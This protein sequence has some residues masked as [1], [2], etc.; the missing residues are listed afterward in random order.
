VGLVPS[1]TTLANG[2]KCKYWVRQGAANSSLPAVVYLPGLREKVYPAARLAQTLCLDD[3]TVYIVDLPTCGGHSV[4]DDLTTP[5]APG[6]LAAYPCSMAKACELVKGFLDH[7]GLNT[8]SHPT[9]FVLVGTSTGGHLSYTFAAKRGAEYPIKGLGLIHPAGPLT[10]ADELLDMIGGNDFTSFPFAWDT[11]AGCRSGY[12]EW[13]GGVMDPGDW[14][15]AGEEHKN[16]AEFPPTYWQRICEEWATDYAQVAKSRAAGASAAHASL[17]PLRALKLP[18]L[19]MG[20]AND[21]VCIAS[22]MAAQ[23]AP[24]LGDAA[25]YVAL[26]YDGGHQIHVDPSKPEKNGNLYD[27]AGPLLAAWMSGTVMAAA[28]ADAPLDEESVKMC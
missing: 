18:A 23:L 4:L 20:S 17:A 10:L 24:A 8:K 1:S 25:E 13:L 21:R 7:V 26:P 27:L 2:W 5:V 6:A 19:V 28:A 12:F 16:S 15:F 14:I 9:G 3:A 11:A 22:K